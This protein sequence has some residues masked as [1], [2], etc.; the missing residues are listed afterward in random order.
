VS[1]C[2]DVMASLENLEKR[3]LGKFPPGKFSR[4]SRKC[5]CYCAVLCEC[6]E[7]AY[8]GNNVLKLSCRCKYLN[9]LTVAKETVVLYSVYLLSYSAILSFW[10]FWRKYM[11][12]QIFQLHSQQVAVWYKLTGHFES[13]LLWYYIPYSRRCS[14]RIWCLDV[15]VG[16]FKSFNSWHV[17]GNRMLIHIASGN[18]EFEWNCLKISL[19]LNVS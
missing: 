7:K 1:G 10:L 11:Q 13:G 8:F 9:M 4:K 5:Y 12:W 18:C 6:H 3:E 19:L 16:C 2:I 15:V 17:Y 14:T